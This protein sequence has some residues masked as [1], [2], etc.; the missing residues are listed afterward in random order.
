MIE[1]AGTAANELIAVRKKAIAEVIKE[2]KFTLAWLPDSSKFSMITFK[3]YQQA[4]KLSEATGLQR[5]Y[6]DRNKPYTKQLKFFNVYKPVNS[7]L[8]PMKYLVPQGRAAVLEL[9][10][11]NNVTMYRLPT[12]TIVE[13]EVYRIDEY[14]SQS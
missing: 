7:V 1:Q 12:D 6:Y 3:G 8:K 2:E 5:M 4:F 13:A 9:L 11:L 14:K 10:K